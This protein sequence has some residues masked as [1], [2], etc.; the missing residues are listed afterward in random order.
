MEVTGIRL[1]RH[2]SPQELSKTEAAAR[3]P[4]PDA[5]SSAPG[6]KEL[7]HARQVSLAYAANLPNFVADE[8]AKRFR[9]GPSSSTWRDFDVIESEIAFKG[10][11]AARQQIRRDGKPWERPFNALP[12]FIWY[13]GFGTEIRP[14]FDPKCPTKLDYA[15][16]TKKSG[17]ALLDYRFS[18]PVDGCFPFFYFDYQRFDP[19]RTGHVFIDDPGGSIIQ[20]DEQA[21]GFPREMQF[22]EREEHISWDYVKIGA[23]TH[24]L[25]VRANFLVRYYDGTRYRIEVEYK[26]HRHFEASSNITFDK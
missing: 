16:R 20:L 6:G 8:R 5:D 19:A 17:R 24:L 22:S 7:A 9:M 10:N 18:S 14:L 23:E 25:P 4:I 11:H 26:N 13:E 15:G 2:A 21:T 1:L 3:Q 12:G